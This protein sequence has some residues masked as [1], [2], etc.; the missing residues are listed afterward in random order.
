[1]EL[2]RALESIFTQK[3][4]AW[5]VSMQ[6]E[7]GL[8]AFMQ[9]HRLDERVKLLTLGWLHRLCV[10]D[11]MHVD[12]FMHGLVLDFCGSY[13]ILSSSP[14]LGFCCQGVVK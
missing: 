5:T 3:Q 1:M 9:D 13:L 2:R 6:A 4:A 8:R 14:P 7:A 10:F 12:L 11:V